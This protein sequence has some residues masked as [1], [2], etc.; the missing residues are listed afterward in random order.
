MRVAELLSDLTSLQVCDPNAAL[1]LVSTRPE[2]S[3]E[4]GNGTTESKEIEDSDLKRAKDLLELHGTVKLA[5]QD[6][7]DKDLNQAR[8]AV[9]RVLRTL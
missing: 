4:Q 8:D 7:T 2:P 9:A 1:A 3:P 5:H 6:G